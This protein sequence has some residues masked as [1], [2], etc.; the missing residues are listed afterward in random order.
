MRLLIVRHAIAEDQE[1]FA[2]RGLPDS[3]RPLTA[4]GKTKMIEAATGLREVAPKL[5]Y[6]IT[7]PFK[8]AAET[9]AIVAKALGLPRP[10][11][12]DVL[13]PERHPREFFEWLKTQPPAKGVGVVGH[14]P[15]LGQ[16]ISWCLTGTVAARFELKKGGVAYIDFPDEPEKGKG[17]LSWLLTPGQLRRMAG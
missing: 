9:A 12:I 3:E 16:L 6:L 11:P 15:H 2:V 17:V 10:E 4:A 13:T 7:S 14:E 5:D 1:E 8:R